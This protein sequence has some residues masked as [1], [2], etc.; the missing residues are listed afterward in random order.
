[1]PRDNE[2]LEWGGS[3]PSRPPVE[4]AGTVVEPPGTVLDRG[5]TDVGA[6]PADGTAAAPGAAVPSMAP[7]A[8]RSVPNNV[9]KWSPP[10][11]TQTGQAGCV[12]NGCRASPDS[13]ASLLSKPTSGACGQEAGAG[14]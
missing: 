11:N 1:M 5:S 10:C 8:A 14:A 6:R 12:S 3:N 13:R 2:D 7:N 9:V 4:P